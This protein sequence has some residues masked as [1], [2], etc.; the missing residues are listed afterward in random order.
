MR[1]RIFYKRSKTFPFLERTT[2]LLAKEAKGRIQIHGGTLEDVGLEKT[3][4]LCA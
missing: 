3:D 2:N 4:F 1:C